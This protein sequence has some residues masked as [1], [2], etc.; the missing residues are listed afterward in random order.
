MRTEGRFRIVRCNQCDLIYVDSRDIT[1]DPEELYGAEYFSSDWKSFCGY[2]NYVA[3]RWLHLRNAHAILTVVERALG[4]PR[5]RLLDVGCAFGFFLEAARARGWAPLGLDVSVEAVKYGQKELGLS[6]LLG[7]IDEGVFE[8]ES[9][10]V[11]SMVGT[12]EHLPDP[13]SAVRAAARVLKPGG[14]LVI[15]TIDVEGVL[16]YFNWKPPEH[17][18][19]FS[20]RTLAYL[21]GKAA[22]S[23]ES[24]RTHWSYYRCSDL[25][26]RLWAYWKLPMPAA[27]G[28]VCESLRLDRVVLKV[29]TNEILV[30][31]RKSGPRLV[32]S[33]QC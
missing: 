28:L 12:I 9:F 27:C 26:T 25:I 24:K 19:Y 21:L 11:V 23:V 3:D 32:M 31:A 8:S 7:E 6:V 18:F 14:L 17:L 5:G 30:L 29:P 20:F 16:G 22:L 2:R 33:G 10:D 15:S 4:R 1:F 13:M